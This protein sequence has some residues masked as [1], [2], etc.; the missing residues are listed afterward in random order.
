[1]GCMSFLTFLFHLL[2]VYDITFRSLCQL[3]L[4]FF[5]STTVDK[6]S[7]EVKVKR[8][9]REIKVVFHFSLYG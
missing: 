3:G 8:V 4:F 7:V 5:F 9:L 2:I 6:M 1:M